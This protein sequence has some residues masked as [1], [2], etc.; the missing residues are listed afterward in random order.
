M[1]IVVLIFVVIFVFIVVVKKLL[2]HV[3]STV[4]PGGATRF[5]Y[6]ASRGCYTVYLRCIQGVL[7]GVS[8]HE[9]QHSLCVQQGI[10]RRDLPRVMEQS[11][12]PGL[13]QFT[14]RIPG[15][16]NNIKIM[17]MMMKK[18]NNIL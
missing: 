5:I 14:E 9:Q 6:G 17:M 3:V 18:M 4:Y 8:G 16:E 10:H 11:L 1:F 2:L 13:E 7:H 12:P 15:G